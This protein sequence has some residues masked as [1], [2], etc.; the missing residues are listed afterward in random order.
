MSKER[1]FQDKQKKRSNKKLQLMGLGI[2]L[3]IMAAV[4]YFN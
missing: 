4:L 2:T 3:G 1:E